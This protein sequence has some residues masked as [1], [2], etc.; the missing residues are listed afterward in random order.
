M[1]RWSRNQARLAH[2]QQIIRCD[3][4][5]RYQGSEFNMQ[6][7]ARGSKLKLELRTCGSDATG[8]HRSLKTSVMGVRF[9]S[10]AFE[11]AQTSVCAAT[12]TEESQTEV[13]ATRGL[14][15]SGRAT[16]PSSLD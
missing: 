16:G 9:S 5:L 15:Q 7:A 13:C 1:R 4:G 8:R 11:V 3:S 12:E 6:V 14:M 10:P 2:N